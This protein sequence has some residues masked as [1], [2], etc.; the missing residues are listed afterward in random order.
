M[1]AKAKVLCDNSVYGLDGIAE[2]GWAVWL[3]TLDG[4][5][6]IDTGQGK[7]LLYN[8]TVF[9]IDLATT[10]AILISHHHYDHTGG[11]LPALGVMRGGPAGTGIPVHAH[12]DLFKESYA[13]PKG[14]KPRY[15]GIPFSRVALEGAGAV[16]NL[17]NE[18][19]EIGEGVH[20]T[21]EV[22]RRSDFELAEPDLKH[23]DKAGELVVDPILDDQSVVI[24]TREG[25]LVILGCSHA[26]VVNILNHIVQKTGRS[27]LHTVIGGTHLG[28]ADEERVTKTI[29]ALLEFDIKRIGVSHCTG[30]KAAAQIA[31]AFGDRFFLCHVGTEVEIS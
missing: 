18:W 1:I 11:L 4:N 28:P 3:E 16:V 19:I 7:A 27:D 15:I 12:Y 22:P 24:E 20:M 26:G 30:P 31:Q 25:L 10:R 17:G 5:F 6:L 2:H 9:G 23:F 13:M 8:A 14:K 21:G 29:S